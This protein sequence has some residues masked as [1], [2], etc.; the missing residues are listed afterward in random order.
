MPSAVF[1]AFLLKRFIRLQGLR[2][3]ILP[4]LGRRWTIRIIALMLPIP[5]GAENRALRPMR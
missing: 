1:T 3:W 4:M 5:I 2:A